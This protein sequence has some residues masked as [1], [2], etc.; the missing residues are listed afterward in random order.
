[1]RHLGPVHNGN[2]PIVA[3]ARTHKLSA[4]VQLHCTGMTTQPCV[5]LSVRLQRQVKAHNAAVLA[6]SH[7]VSVGRVLYIGRTCLRSASRC[8]QPPVLA[9][10]LSAAVSTRVLSQP[11][12]R[13]TTA[14]KSRVTARCDTG[15][16]RE[17]ES[18]PPVPNVSM[19][20]LRRV[21]HVEEE[22]MMCARDVAGDEHEAVV[23]RF[24]RGMRDVQA[25][26]LLAGA[27]AHALRMSLRQFETSI[28]SV[29]RTSTLIAQEAAA[30][31]TLA[32]YHA[33][34][35]RLVALACELVP[36]LDATVQCLNAANRV[37]A[38]HSRACASLL[39]VR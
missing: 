18:R 25:T 27:H 13:V 22:L 36:R 17:A 9:T 3:S 11:P 39:S 21:E 16:H 12:T 28:V 26:R 32:G 6:S 23:A 30:C 20:G 7:A 10:I 34:K 14:S 29:T 31:G 2:G 35:R 1:M 15:T 4:L 5:R 33:A 19:A 8:R 38:N 37:I 24:E